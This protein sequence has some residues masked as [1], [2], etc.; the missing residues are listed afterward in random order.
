MARH[1][2]YPSG[3]ASAG[4]R[5]CDQS[6]HQTE[7]ER[8]ADPSSGLRLGTSQ[9]HPNGSPRSKLEGEDGACRALY[10]TT[11]AI[12]FSRNLHWE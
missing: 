4:Q 11:R 3:F 2:F 12:Q 8:E 9:Y 6:F 10:I 7:C 5:T 1:R